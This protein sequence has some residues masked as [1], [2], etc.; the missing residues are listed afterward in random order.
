[1]ASPPLYR[2]SVWPPALGYY[3]G[4]FYHKAALNRVVFSGLADLW[5]YTE[6]A[7]K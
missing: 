2:G 3:H 5:L 6:L 4:L 7:D 1:M